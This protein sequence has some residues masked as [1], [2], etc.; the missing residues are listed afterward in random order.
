MQVEQ[1]SRATG[2]VRHIALETI[3]SSNAEALARA[4]AGER[5]PLWITADSQTNGRGRSG[6]TWISPKGNLYATL[7]LNEPCAAAQSPQLAFVAGLA[8][9]DAVA[10]CAPE[11]VAKLALKWPNDLLLSG[12]RCGRT[13]RNRENLLHSA[14]FSAYR[15]ALGAK[16]CDRFVA[17]IHDLASMLDRELPDSRA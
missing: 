10:Q 4:R 2:D 15:R 5:G 8:L 6:R 9:F 7:L 11:L 3:G 14:E 17:A 1:S 13:H 12:R 16:R